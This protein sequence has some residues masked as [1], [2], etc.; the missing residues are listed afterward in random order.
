MSLHGNR[1]DLLL[2]NKMTLKTDSRPLLVFV[3]FHI[4]QKTGSGWRWSRN[5]TDLEKHW[6]MQFILFSDRATFLLEKYV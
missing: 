6:I 1:L 3:F 4:I 2:H 5:K